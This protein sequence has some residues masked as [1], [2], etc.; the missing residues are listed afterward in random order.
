M[1]IKLQ[2]DFYNLIGRSDGILQVFDLVER[3][4]DSDSTVILTG[5]SGTGKELIARALHHNSRRD[6]KGFIPVNCGAIPNELLES[7][8]FGHE[9]GAFTGAMQTRIGRMEMADNGTLFLDEIGDMPMTLQVKLLRVLAESEIDRVG[10]SKPIKINVRV[11]TATHCNL[12]EAIAAGRFREDLFYRLN[13]IPIAIPPLRERQSD[14]PLLVHHYLKHFN[15]QKGKSIESISDAAIEILCNYQWPGNIRELA[16]FM[17]RMV[18]LSTDK[19]LTPRDLPEKVMSDVPKE[20]W[21]PLVQAESDQTPAEFIRK[22]RNHAHYIGMPEEGVNLK[23]M[24]EEFEKELIIEALEKT[25]GVKNQA[26]TLLGLNRT[27]LVE[28]LKKMKIHR[29]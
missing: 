21:E 26:A 14:I 13:V 3:A 6:S 25:N 15:Q 8:L 4:A 23:Q 10:G 16:N 28:K 11:I 1:A 18:V 12:E 27:T 2:T 5:E 20:T 17:E 22:S 29:P 7:E 19:T 9:K 24:V